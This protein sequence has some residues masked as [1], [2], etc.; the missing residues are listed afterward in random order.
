[1]SWTESEKLN[2]WIERAFENGRAEERE[3]I[4]KLLEEDKLGLV[5]CGCC[6]EANMEDVIALIKGEQ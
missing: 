2:E 6:A 1:M 4:I 5:G 3:R